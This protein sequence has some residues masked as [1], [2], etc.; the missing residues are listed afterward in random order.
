MKPVMPVLRRSTGKVGEWV[1][2]LLPWGLFIALLA[3]GWRTTDLFHTVP[4]Y[5]DALEGI[6]A[7][8]WYDNALRLGQNPWVYRLAFHPQGWSVITYAWGPANFA[9]LLPLSWLGGP[10][11]AYNVATLITFVIAFAGTLQLARGFVSRLS[12]TV[13]ALLFTFWGLRWYNNIGQLNIALASALLPW[14]LWSLERGFAAPRRAAGWFVLAGVLWTVSIN[15]TLYFIWLGGIALLAWIVG[16]LGFKWAKWRMFWSRVVLVLV[17]AGALSLPMLVAFQ[18]ATTSAGTRPF[19]FYDVNVLGASVNSFPI[20]SLSHPWLGG[21]A[22]MLYHGSPDSEHNLTNLGLLGTVMAFVG[23]W[24][25]RRS[26]RWRPVLILACVGFILALGLTLKWD[27]LPIKF[28]LLRPVNELIWRVGYRVNPQFYFAEPPIPP[29]LTDVVPLPTLTL[30]TFVPFFAQARV[31]ARYALLSGIAVFLLAGF[32]LD[33]VKRQWIRLILAALLVVEVVPPPTQSYEYPPP[34]HPAYEWLRQQSLGAN[35]I[36]EFTTDPE[37]RLELSLGGP[38][39]WATN[40]HQQAT[41]GGA[42]SI[43]PGHVAYL[44]RWLAEHPEPFEHPDFVSLLRYFR[45]IYMV[46][47]MSG[48][49]QEKSLAEAK[50]NQELRFVQCF[51]PTSQALLYDNQICVLEVLPSRT[52]NLNLLFREGW[53]GPEEWGRWIDGTEAKASW[54]ATGKGPHYLHV[55]AFPYCVSGQQQQVS[56]EVNGTPVAEHQWTDCEP[57]STNTAIPVGLIP[58]GPNDV[59]IRTDYA[60]QPI[61]S[62]GGEIGDPRNLS[63]GF[64]ELRVAEE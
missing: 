30:A 42:S 50:L 16:R 31:L 46:L 52:P 18:Q 13:V 58:I 47:T 48:G 38:A 40:T 15:S 5:G 19:T 2:R 24:A 26:Q 11:F 32:G 9:L 43:I 51:A 12:G 33:Q 45:V 29:G 56:V 14:M 54:I 62:S 7:I 63:V 55:Q 59:V 39:I 20:P 37:L 44:M 36:V 21:L 4:A 34:S 60:V 35:G 17:V 22:R 61:D 64:T 41:V 49:G 8:D 10:A 6:W 23:I 3:W 27:D 57:W 28:S 53:S 25:G 1:A